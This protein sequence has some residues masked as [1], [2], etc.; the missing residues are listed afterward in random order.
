M[1]NGFR[2]READ[3]ILAEEKCREAKKQIQK[4]EG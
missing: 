1:I 2:Q 3:G 4:R